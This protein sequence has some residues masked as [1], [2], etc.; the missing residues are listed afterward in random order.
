MEQKNNDFEDFDFL[1]EE[2]PEK[3][4]KRPHDNTPQLSNLSIFNRPTD[5]SASKSDFQR[6]WEKRNPKIQAIVYDETGFSYEVRKINGDKQLA[7]WCQS[8]GQAQF[9]YPTKNGSGYQNNEK[10]FFSTQ[11]KQVMTNSPE[12]IN[13]SK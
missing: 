4:P 5:Y 2:F 8:K 13:C 9:I 3:M 11:K 7:Y 10:Q 12:A 1:S 6:L